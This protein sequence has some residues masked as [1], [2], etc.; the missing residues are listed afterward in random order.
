MV[1]VTGTRVNTFMILDYSFSSKELVQL[2]QLTDETMETHGVTRSKTTMTLPIAHIQVQSKYLTG[3]I[4]LC[5]PAYPLILG[6]RYVPLLNLDIL[7]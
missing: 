4:P 6:C 5:Y 7:C 3:A 2:G 1:L